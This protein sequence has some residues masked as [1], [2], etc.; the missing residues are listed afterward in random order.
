MEK[1]YTDT[2]FQK[3]NNNYTFL[4]YEV[5]QLMM[6]KS[7]SKLI[8]LQWFSYGSK[9]KCFLMTVQML[10]VHISGAPDYI[11]STLRNLVQVRGCTNQKISPKKL[12]ML[13][14]A[15]ESGILVITFW[16]TSISLSMPL[17]ADRPWNLRIITVVSMFRRNAS[18]WS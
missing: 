7:R 14:M 15:I 9:K 4:I 12:E 5:S 6:K 16:D 13:Q 17:R 18:L 8:N 11:Q 2:H 3:N 10:K 1:I